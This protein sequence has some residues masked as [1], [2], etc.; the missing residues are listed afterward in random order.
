VFYFIANPQRPTEPLESIVL[1]PVLDG[2][3]AG[4]LRT[5]IDR[6][7]NDYLEL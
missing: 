3:R 5:G 7:F 2:N 6:K 1:R 4:K